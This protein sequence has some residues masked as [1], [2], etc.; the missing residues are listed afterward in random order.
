MATILPLKS[1]LYE[2]FQRFNAIDRSIEML[3][4]IEFSKITIKIKNCKT[5]CKAQTVSRLKEIIQPLLSHTPPDK[6]SRRLWNKN[7]LKEIYRNIETF[8]FKVFQE[9]SFQPSRN[10]AVQINIFSD[11]KL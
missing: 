9:C 10:G 11:T 6:S 1:K 8:T 5:F 3:K 2:N 4:I 7:F